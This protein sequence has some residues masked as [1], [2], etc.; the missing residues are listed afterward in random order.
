MKQF[1]EEQDEL[2]H[3]RLIPLFWHEGQLFPEITPA[4]VGERAPRITI[5]HINDLHS[6][7]DGRPDEAGNRRGGLARVAT[8]IQRARAAGPT[9][10]FDLGDIVFGGGTWW[11]IQG[12][13]A[14]ATLRGKAGCDLATIGNH[15]LE[16]GIAGLRE[17]LTG[18]YPL[19]SANLQVEDDAVQRQIYPAYLI[20]IGGWRIGVTGLTTLATYDLI[21]SRL[22][23]GITIAD[24]PQAAL[25]VVA[26]LEPMV[27]TIVILSHLGFHESGPGD[28]DLATRLAGSKVSLILGAH[29]HTALDPAPVLH[30]ITICNAG[31][32]S[33]NVGEVTLRYHDQ[34]AIEVQ[35]RLLPQDQTVPADPLWV[36]ARALIAQTF[37]PFHET[38]FPLRNLPGLNGTPLSREDRERE[39][40]LLARSLREAG[41]SPSEAVLMVPLLSLVERFPQEERA[42]LTELMTTY[43]SLEHLVEVKI[44]GK[45]LKELLTLQPSLLYYQQ[46]RPL[47][48]SDET[49]LLPEQ[50]EEQRVYT[51]ITTELICE[52]GL[53]WGFSLAVL[54]APVRSLNITCLQVV[55]EYLTSQQECL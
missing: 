16:H 37:R 40:A 7:V 21:P 47:R 48:L 23:Q 22:L 32:Y 11:D 2:F 33:A 54:L 49:E 53:G 27:D 34:G 3:P 42:T 14:V 20:E 43:P 28:P 6:S 30:G 8:T 17:L 29:T 31:A 25:Q 41:S 5:L 4:V 1:A 45:A 9:L 52:G 55:R 46:T 24:P 51:I 26:A 13:E 44:S 12:I 19:A 35:A 39:R 15:D 50:V 38:V 36:E 10:A 18:G